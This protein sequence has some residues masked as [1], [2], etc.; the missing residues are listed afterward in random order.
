MKNNYLLE[1]SDS[2][3]LETTIKDLINKNGFNDKYIGEYDLEEVLLDNALE[4]LDTYSFLSDKKVII[5]KNVFNDINDKKLKH[6]FK[7]I[8]NSNSDNLLILTVKKLDN[9]LNLVKELKKNKNIDII[10]ISI[11]PYRFASSLLASYK[12]DN[13]S[14]NL[15]I[16]LCNND[17]TRINS[18]CRKLMTFRISE[19]VISYDDVKELVV[20]KLGDSNEILFALIKDI[21]SKDKKR[22]LKRY[23]QLCEYGVDSNS[24][25]GLMTSQ[26]RLIH[27]VKLLAETN[28]SNQEIASSLNLKS[29][30]QVKKA[31]ESI[32]NYTYDEI[33]DFVNKLA[34]IDLNI[35]S[36]RLDKN[37]AIDMLII[38][39]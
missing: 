8:D 1:S 27:Q 29:P 10:S 16:E 38:N 13:S 24:I 28:M 30:Y 17:I 3:S 31:K 7:Y 2:L 5:I 19:K 20:K 37:M 32:Y 39:L 33:Y 26:I 14:I 12:I 21:I 9:R 35:K 4:D 6:L 22:A 36:G 11:D 25:I 15:L 34:N 18:E 23:R